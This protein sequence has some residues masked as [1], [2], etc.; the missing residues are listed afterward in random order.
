MSVWLLQTFR[1]SLKPT[2]TFT[3]KL[4]DNSFAQNCS[5]APPFSLSPHSPRKAPAPLPS[6]SSFWPAH[7]AQST[8]NSSPDLGKLL[9][10][11]LYLIKRK[12]LCLPFHPP[13]QNP[14]CLCGL[15]SSPSSSA[16]SLTLK[17][18]VYPL[19]WENW[20]STR[21]PGHT[22]FPSFAPWVTDVRPLT[23]LLSISD[24]HSLRKKLTVDGP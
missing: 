13:Q 16:S 9:C 23:P 18:A 3:P 15:L 20:H 22:G 7:P 6:D 1:F 4:K 19:H 24:N 5:Q 8:T 14:T 21:L 17:A 2:P 11:G 10:W 12:L